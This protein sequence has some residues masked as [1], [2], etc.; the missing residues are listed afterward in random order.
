[1]YAASIQGEGI[2]A[3]SKSQSGLGM[4]QAWFPTGEPICGRGS[5]V[6]TSLPTGLSEWELGPRHA[7]WSPIANY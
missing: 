6:P 7:E 1:M 2:L 4:M 3:K 5:C